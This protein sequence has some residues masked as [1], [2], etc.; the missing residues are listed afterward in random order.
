[1][2]TTDIRDQRDSL[3]ET[4]RHADT[5]ASLLLL[6]PGFALAGGSTVASLDGT[7]ALLGSWALIAAVAMAAPIGA[8]IWP[9]SPGASTNEIERLQEIVEVK[10]RWI[11]T[12]IG[13]GALA[14]TLAAATVITLGVQ[15]A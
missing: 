10:L 5:K 12:A 6:A 9:R 14:L 1:M 15:T 2:N 8:A 13:L 11:R 4:T 7:A 3:R